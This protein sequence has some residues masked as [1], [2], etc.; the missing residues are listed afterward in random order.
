MNIFLKIT[1]ENVHDFWPDGTLHI[2][3][4]FLVQK[5]LATILGPEG[6]VKLISEMLKVRSGNSRNKDLLQ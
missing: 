2:S 5:A 6:F 1:S 4:I 3:S